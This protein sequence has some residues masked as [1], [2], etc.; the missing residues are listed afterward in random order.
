MLE[1]VERRGGAR[2]LLTGAAGVVGVGWWQ[3]DLDQQVQV[4][5]RLACRAASLQR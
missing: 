5:G 1:R 2:P 3:R 4:A